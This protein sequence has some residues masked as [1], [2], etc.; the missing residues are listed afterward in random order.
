MRLLADG[1]VSVHDNGTNLGRAP[2]MVRFRIDPTNMTA[3]VVQTI[4]DPAI[5]SSFC[6]GS[7]RELGSGNWLIDWG[8]TG[9]VGEYQSDGSLVFKLQFSNNLFS[10]RAFP[11][12]SG[13]LSADS[14]RQAMT[15]MFPR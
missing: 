7:A 14:L 2:R 8:R 5:S 12:P 3:A 4:S 11:V 13:Q 9:T 6:C 15:T 10:Y 1:T